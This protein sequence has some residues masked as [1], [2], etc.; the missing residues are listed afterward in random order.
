MAVTMPNKYLHGIS[1]KQET[2]PA[3]K[4]YNTYTMTEDRLALIVVGRLHNTVGVKVALNSCIGVVFTLMG[5]LAI[6]F[7]LSLLLS[8]R[9]KPW[10]DDWIMLTAYCFSIGF[11]ISSYVSVRWGVGLPVEDAPPSWPPKAIQVSRTRSPA[12]RNIGLLHSG[13]L[14]HRDILLL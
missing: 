14:R 13:C 1:M 11:M 5:S 6:W 3:D 7:R 12:M 2:E 10:F 8:R 9:R 4:T